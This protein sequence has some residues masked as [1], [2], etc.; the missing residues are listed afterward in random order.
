MWAGAPRD[1]RPLLKCRNFIPRTT[2]QSLDDPVAG[3][4]CSK[5]VN[6][7]ERKTWTQSEFFTWRNSVRGHE[8]PKMY[9]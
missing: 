2:P 5:A 3:V 1:G 8:P 9:T 7:G 4:P 6:I